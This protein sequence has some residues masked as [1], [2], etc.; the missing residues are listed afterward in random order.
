MDF[1]GKSVQKIKGHRD[2]YIGNVA[3]MNKIIGIVLRGMY[4][5]ANSKHLEAADYGHVTVPPFKNDLARDQV[6]LG[7]PWQTYPTDK[8]G[9]DIAEKFA[10]Y[11]SGRKDCTQYTAIL[12]VLRQ[13]LPIVMYKSTR[14][15][16]DVFMM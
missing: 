3:G 6:E 15:V 10:L 2:T 5:L 11:L 16:S 14:K 8:E 7:E 13:G 4:P 1:A 9:K 12:K